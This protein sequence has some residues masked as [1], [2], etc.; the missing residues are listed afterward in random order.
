MHPSFSSLFSV[1]L[2]L[3]GGRRRASPDGPWSTQRTLN[4]H[5]SNQG[6]RCCV[7]ASG[8]VEPTSTLSFPRNPIL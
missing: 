2:V 4:G 6:A 7:V 1:C 3:R 5:V 8:F